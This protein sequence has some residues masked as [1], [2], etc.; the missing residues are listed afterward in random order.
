MCNIYI[1]VQISNALY[2]IYNLDHIERKLPFLSMHGNNDILYEIAAA[3]KKMS[4]FEC[5]NIL[6]V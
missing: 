6:E 3:K 2:N 4:I 5:F 1:H